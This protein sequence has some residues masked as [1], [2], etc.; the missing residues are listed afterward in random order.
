MALDKEQKITEEIEKTYLEFI[1]KH[2]NDYIL[3]HGMNDENIVELKKL[4]PNSKF[5]DLNKAT[6]TFFDY[7]KILE[8]SKENK[9]E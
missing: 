9:F 4:N 5:V 2:G 7:I 1:S 3:Y 6:N 8:N